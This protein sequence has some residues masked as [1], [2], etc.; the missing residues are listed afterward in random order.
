MTCVDRRKQLKWRRHVHHIGQCDARSSN[1][2]CQAEIPARRHC[3]WVTDRSILRPEGWLDTL[4]VA[5]YRLRKKGTRCG[6]VVALR[7]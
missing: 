2:K 5:E 4:S 7:F 1:N 6:M 3:G